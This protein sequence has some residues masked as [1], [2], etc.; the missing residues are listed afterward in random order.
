MK[1]FVILLLIAILSYLV[2]H[3]PL[4][5]KSYVCAKD[6][7]EPCFLKSAFNDMDSCERAKEKGNYVCSEVEG[8]EKVICTNN[9]SVLSSSTC[10]K[11][12]WL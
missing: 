2:L 7:Q 1:N 5:I 3:D 12:K 8:T 10:K 11:R 9:A 4:P 6:F